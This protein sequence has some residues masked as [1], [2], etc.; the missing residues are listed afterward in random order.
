MNTVEELRACPIEPEPKT[1]RGYRI[2]EPANGWPRDFTDVILEMLKRGYEITLVPCG[3]ATPDRPKPKSTP[4][5]KK[6]NYIHEYS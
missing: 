2:F 4:E 6:G 3:T 1:V 5:V